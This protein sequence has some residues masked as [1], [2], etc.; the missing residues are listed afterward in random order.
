MCVC[1]CLYVAL[2]TR[3]VVEH[4]GERVAAEGQVRRAGRVDIAVVDVALL[5]VTLV[6]VAV[7]CSVL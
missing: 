2:S 4:E 1:V 3:C 6:H 5:H 7:C